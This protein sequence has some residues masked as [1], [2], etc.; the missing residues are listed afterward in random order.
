MEVLFVL[1][2]LA[3]TFAAAA[4]GVFLWA[5]RTGQFDDLVTPA[6]RAL[7]DGEPPGQSADGAARPPPRGV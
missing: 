6:M 3:L 4:V 2:P 5:A 7:H 1:L